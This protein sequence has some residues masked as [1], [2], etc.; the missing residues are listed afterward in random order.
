MA[1][2]VHCQYIHLYCAPAKK[3][4]KKTS[5]V[6]S[7]EDDYFFSCIQPFIVLQQQKAKYDINSICDDTFHCLNMKYIMGGF[8]IR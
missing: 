7:E 1:V 4:Q 2:N 6:R 5:D 8:E 3:K